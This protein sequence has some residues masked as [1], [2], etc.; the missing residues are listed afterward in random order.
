MPAPGEAKAVLP[1][2]MALFSSS[3]VRAGKLLFTSTMFACC[4]TTAIGSRSFAGS[5]PALEKSVGFTA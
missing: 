1:F 4:A 3:N 5:Y 2:C